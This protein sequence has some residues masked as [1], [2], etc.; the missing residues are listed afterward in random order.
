[1]K[2][3]H[4]L[5]LPSLLCP[6][7]QVFDLGQSEQ[8]ERSESTMAEQRNTHGSRLPR[9]EEG[10]SRTLQQVGVCFTAM[11]SQ[12]VPGQQGGRMA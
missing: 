1:M 4:G 9:L 6:P 12:D 2:P 7:Q 3:H 10:A 11:P 5:S 8:T